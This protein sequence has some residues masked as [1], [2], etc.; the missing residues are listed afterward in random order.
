MSIKI[1]LVSNSSWSFYKFRK[2]IIKNLI[3]LG[4]E[5]ILMSPKDEFINELLHL[6]TKFF[7]LK[8]FRDSFEKMSNNRGYGLQSC[9]KDI[10][11]NYRG[12]WSK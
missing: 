3:D 11:K 8:K 12:R 10:F 2:G 7:E 4:Y 9:E 6:G 1:A 5:V